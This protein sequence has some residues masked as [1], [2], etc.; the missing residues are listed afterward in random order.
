MKYG[1]VLFL[2]ALLLA[3]CASVSTQTYTVLDQTCS[4]VTTRAQIPLFDP[5]QAYTV[6]ED[7]MGH[8]SY[9]AGSV[10]S[11]SISSIPGVIQGAATAGSMLGGF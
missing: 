6:C 11:N 8:I 4:A 2:G 10:Q 1:R 5:T 9:P 7:R 3:G